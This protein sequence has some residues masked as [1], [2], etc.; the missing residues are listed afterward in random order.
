MEHE[1]YELEINIPKRKNRDYFKH[2]M[3]HDT[4]GLPVSYTHL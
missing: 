1:Q 3:S 2:H 4:I